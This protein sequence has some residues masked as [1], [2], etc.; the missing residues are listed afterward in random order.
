MSTPILSYV[1]LRDYRPPIADSWA[2]SLAQ[3]G[4]TRLRTFLSDPKNLL[5]SRGGDR[6]ALLLA[7][8]LFDQ[9]KR[10]CPSIRI[11]LE[12]ISDDRLLYF[13]WRFPVVR[14]ERTPKA[15]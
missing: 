6:D 11:S 5:R 8:D 7:G 3:L 14:R 15:A 12:G 9:A 1:M 10:D 4:H 13:G 2:M